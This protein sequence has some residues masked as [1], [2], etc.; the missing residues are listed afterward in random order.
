VLGPLAETPD[1]S[2]AFPRLSD[3]QIDLLARHGQRRPVSVGDV[4]YQEGET[5]CD[6][7]AVL[8]GK[9]AIL[10]GYGI[11]ND[12][13]GVHGAGRFLGELNLLTGEAVYVTA[14][15]A[16]PGE[17]LVVP[18]DEIRRLVAQDQA[19]GDLILR[20]YLLRR[21]LLIELGAGLK[22]V[23]SRFSRDTQRLREFAA[24]NRLPHRFVDVEK[25]QAAETLLR[26]L[27]IGPHETP[28]VIWRAEKVLRNPTNAQLATAIGLRATS[29]PKVNDLVVVGAGPAGL[30][31]AVYGASEGLSTV[32]LESVAAGGQA[33]TSPRIENYLGFPSGISG[34]DLAERAL[35]QAEKFGA[36][37]TV[38]AEATALDQRDSHHVV[39]LDDGTSVA[40][41]A[42]VIATGARYRRL[43]LARL[44]E[45]EG[46]SVYYAATQMEAKVCRGDP[47]VVVGGGNS[48]G[49]ASLFLA[50]TASRVHLVVRDG[51]LGKTMSR[52]LIDQIE[53][54]P[55]IEVHRWHEV[56]ELVGEKGV[57]DGVVVEDNGTGERRT[58]EAKALFVFIGAEPYV[59]WLGDAIALDARGFVLT[60]EDAVAHRN[61]DHPDGEHPPSIFETS[62]PGVF[63]VG[64][65]R[66]GSVK[67]VASAVGEA[68]MAVR[69]VHEYLE[70][71]GADPGR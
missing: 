4:L 19:L 36:V 63:A 33:G 34:S 61:G 51:D 38:P 67:R 24:R 43:P 70:R 40:G 71:L 41:R 47:V 28:V 12:V 58:L 44:E 50:K 30:T 6:F 1:V 22:I 13:I 66:S 54:H 59:R 55:A 53:R 7:Y 2:G 8:D 56:R 60:G 21:S 25:D 57:L 11:E 9:V 26:Q 42:V 32:T 64:D 17:V 45:F 20:A 48:A 52:Y 15:V 35:I 49:Q 23:G 46:T 10:Q 39:T 14:V 68:A 18:V 31:A 16:E 5:I 65:V 37:I 27:G 29:P 62:R 69:F 3:A